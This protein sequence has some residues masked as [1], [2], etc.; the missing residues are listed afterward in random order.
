MKR[1]LL[2][3]GVLVML[4]AAQIVFGQQ[5]EGMVTYEVK[6][7][8]HRRIPPERA[9]MKDMIPEF[10]VM[11]YQLFF[12]TIE[13]LYK[14][15]IEDE[16]PFEH[17]GGPGRVRFRRPNEEVYFNSEQS[18]RIA[19]QEMMGKKYL[20]EDSM[21]VAPW[22]LGTETKALL[23]RTCKQASYYNEERKQNIVAWYT[24]QLR[25]LLGP[26]SFNSLP[27]AVLQVDINDGERIITATQIEQR[28]LKK[29]EI[30]VPS[31]GQSITQ[32]EFKKL[33]DAQ[34]ERMRSNG[35]NMMIRN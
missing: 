11:Q 7:N 29:N 14:P 18:K 26:E 9:G 3:M 23:G 17:E 32:Q 2:L 34:M 21:K 13:S 15:V 8:M 19:L 33:E 24:D 16:E 12:N 25:P 1:I 5:T 30:K 10:N 4:T 22:K 31:G 28:P 27:G 20:I 35:G 6:V